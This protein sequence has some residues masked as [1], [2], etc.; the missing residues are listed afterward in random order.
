MRGTAALAV[1]PSAAGSLELGDHPN[2]R[3]LAEL[4]IAPKP[5]FTAFFP[6]S[7]GVL[8]DH[9]ESWFVSSERAPES[10]PEGFESVIGLGLGQDWPEPPKRP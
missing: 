8:D 5:L 4:G 9:F 6:S 3:R 1:G 7:T 10:Q 2:A